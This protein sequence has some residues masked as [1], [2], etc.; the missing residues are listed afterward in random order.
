M[1]LMQNQMRALLLF[2]VWRC[3][4]HRS[5]LVQKRMIKSQGLDS[6]MYSISRRMRCRK[7]MSVFRQG[8]FKSMSDGI[9]WANQEVPGTHDE[10]AERS[11]AMLK[12]VL[13]T[14]WGD[15]A[16]EDPANK[17]KYE[18]ENEEWEA[19][20]HFFFSDTAHR[21][22]AK[23]RARHRC[24]LKGC[25]F[26]CRSLAMVRRK[27]RFHTNRVW[28]SKVTPLFEPARWTQHVESNKWFTSLVTVD[29]LAF[30]GALEG[31]SARNKSDKNKS[32]QV[33]LTKSVSKLKRPDLQFGF[34]SGLIN[35]SFLESFIGLLF[36][37]H[38]I[39][40]GHATV[41]NKRKDSKFSQTFR[42]VFMVKR[43]QTT[44]WAILLGS[45]DLPEGIGEHDDVRGLW[46][47]LLAFQA[48][49]TENAGPVLFHCA[50]MLY[51]IWV[52]LATEHDL[53]VFGLCVHE[54]T[55]QDDSIAFQDKLAAW[56]RSAD[57]LL[58]P[59]TPFCCMPWLCQGWKLH[60]R[61]QTSQGNAQALALRRQYHHFTVPDHEQSTL[62]E[63]RWNSFGKSAAGGMQCAPSSFAHQASSSFNASVGMSFQ[64]SPGGRDLKSLPPSLIN[65]FKQA[66]KNPHTV[67]ARPEQKGSLELWTVNY[68]MQ[69]AGQLS[70]PMAEKS[71][72]MKARHAEFKLLDT[73]AKM[74][75]TTQSL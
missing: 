54:K 29:A 74:E 22:S 18:K 51:E 20:F 70:L 10:A 45:H 69:E 50:L 25:G 9:V 6:S 8:Y 73:A 41:D 40:T 26:T 48:N 16:R 24:S 59:T 39:N 68:W 61:A 38:S 67:Y 19:W 35:A 23:D 57:A 75:Y 55:E 52:K 63:E 71:D 62:R 72:I 37:G 34:L 14:R 5:G 33:R 49:D 65:S 43:L 2:Y 1:V 17:D 56:K 3:Y 47:L 66:S 46:N 31:V 64:E 42:I 11:Y 36:H 60:I 53:F 58:S 15:A 28:L 21:L 32:R 4:L 27:A 44:L 13:T 7:D 12:R 30:V